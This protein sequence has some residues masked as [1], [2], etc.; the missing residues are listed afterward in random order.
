MTL[1]KEKG[2]DV[3]VWALKVT[4]AGDVVSGDSKGEVCFWDSKN[5]TLKQRLKAHEADCLTLEVGGRNGD[6]V[7]SGGADMRTVM[8]QVAGNT[9]RWGEVAKRRFHKHDVRAMAAYESG[10]F[11]VVVSGGEN[12]CKL[13]SGRC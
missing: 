1:N 8:F 11:S 3:L 6:S 2:R 12:S 9:Q 10:P 7:I 13:P 5:W 4:K